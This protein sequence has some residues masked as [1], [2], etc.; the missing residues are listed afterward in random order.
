MKGRKNGLSL[1]N[2]FERTANTPL[3]LLS[4]LKIQNLS[5]QRPSENS[6]FRLRKNQVITHTN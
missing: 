1:G 3:S 6:S 4:S 5:H 2:V